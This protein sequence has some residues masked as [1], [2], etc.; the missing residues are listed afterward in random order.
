MISL[1]VDSNVLISEDLLGKYIND[2]QSN[3]VLGTD[4]IYGTLY[5]VT[6]YTGFSSDTAEQSGHYLVFH[7]ES[8]D[9]NA[10]IKVQL[11]NGLHDEVTLD[12]DGIIIIRITD[13]ASQ[14][15]KITVSG[16]EYDDI[17]KVYNLTG[18]T[19]AD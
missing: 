1:L 12:D 2:L 3:I 14:K 11:I 15:V 7:C 5:N 8:T 9:N 16:D 13:K 6:D 18:L 17:I 19:L 4:T 10:T